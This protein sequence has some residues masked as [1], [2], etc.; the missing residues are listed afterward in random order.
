MSSLA[1]MI[2]AG[3]SAAAL[4]VPAA[5]GQAA[6]DEAAQRAVVEQAADAL[7]N[8]YIFPDV[9]EKAAAKLEAQLAGGAYK[10]LQLRDFAEKLT[11]D[12]YDVTKDK[13][14]RVSAPG[15]S[16]APAGSPPRSP[17]PRS[18]GGVVR[19]DRLAGNIGYIEVVGFPP[20][21][22]FKLGVDPSMAALKDTKALIVDIRRNGGGSPDAVAYLVSHFLD[23]SKPPIVINDFIGRTPGTKDF[24]TRQSFSVKTPVSYLGKPVYVLTSVRT[25]SGGEEFAYDI[26]AFKL[27]TLVGETTGGGANPG[28]V[29]P[30][31]S[32]LGIFM[33][34]GR[35]VNPVTK[36]NWEG[37]GVVPDVKTPPEDALKVA[38]EKLGQKPAAKD[39]DA[40]SE[41]KLF[42]PRTTPHPQGEAVLRRGI[43][44]L[45]RGEPNYDLMTPAMAETTRRQLASL[46]ETMTSLGELKEVRFVEVGPQGLDT[47]D[48]TFANGSVTW[49]MAL[50]G[51]GKLASAGFT[52]NAAPQPKPQ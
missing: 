42:Q 51:E 36:T 10:D 37:V 25:F 39:I 1:R 33:P 27:G 40:L 47:Y 4:L 49:R 20:T 28:G 5:A 32:Q 19:A 44:E 15:V 45:V 43:A 29:M 35:P 26:Q 7:R 23:G 31:G 38:L 17:P 2:A 3:L 48:L 13:H 46:K 18:Q 52:R 9:G 16:L 11:A 41:T 12:L 6:L 30:I 34:N 50:D 21:D 22:A 14:M 8:R 24:T